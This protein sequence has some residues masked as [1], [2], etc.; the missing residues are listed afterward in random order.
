VPP[1]FAPT[2]ATEPSTA[3]PSPTTVAPVTNGNVEIRYNGDTI[4]FHNITNTDVNL[5][6]VQLILVG[7][8]AADSVLF[9]AEEWD[10]SNNILQPDRCA[11]VWRVEFVEL[12]AS[13]APA[14]QCG[15]RSAYRA[16][17]RTFWIV[18]GEKTMFEL[19]RDN[20]VLAQCPSARRNINT[21][22]TC[23]ADI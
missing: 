21:I 6:G 22:L 3:T 5:T 20:E 7:Q 9:L 8:D 13:E 15:A 18:D 4:V 2:T 23:M 16:T 11:Q 1:T 14:N 19:R 12:P 17:P 10:M